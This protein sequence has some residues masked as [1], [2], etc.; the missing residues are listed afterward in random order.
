MGIIQKEKISSQVSDYIKR[1]I[2]TRKLRDGDR[3][4]ESQIARQLGISQA[5]VREALKELEGMGM[6]EIRPYSGCYVLPFDETKLN[7][8]YELRSLLEEYAANYAVNM[9]SSEDIEEMEGLLEDMRKDAD[10]DDK[11]SLIENDVL[12]HEVLVK[13][14]KNI[15]L[16]KMWRI[17]S[18]PQW[19]SLTILSYGDIHYFSE[20]H[21]VLI[22]CLKNHD[23]ER[24]KEEL[25][26]HFR[27][28]ADIARKAVTENG[29]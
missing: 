13:A 11:W 4:V 14:A 24:L 22:E 2:I 26:K 17:A 1:Q 29:N 23:G 8:A 19:S 27:N 9:I 20:S 6:I 21:A 25:H 28:A 16:E 18:V 7:Q 3:I 15:M 12:F 5:P 10:R